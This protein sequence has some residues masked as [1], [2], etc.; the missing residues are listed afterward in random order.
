[1]KVID[2]DKGEVREVTP[3]QA[4]IEIQELCHNA[5]H[6]FGSSYPNE[7]LPTARCMCGDITYTEWKSKGGD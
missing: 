5:G 1:M 2:F 3:E 6:Y 7:P 4:R